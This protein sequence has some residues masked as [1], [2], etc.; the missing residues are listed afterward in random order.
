MQY[1][2]TE[3]AQRI[4]NKCRKSKDHERKITR[5][6]RVSDKQSSVTSGVQL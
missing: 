6:P 3:Y 5:R 4:R 1:L 2:Q